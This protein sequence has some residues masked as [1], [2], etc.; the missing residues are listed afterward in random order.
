MST[1]TTAESG[2]A[3]GRRKNAGPLTTA[4]HA[5]SRCYDLTLDTGVLSTLDQGGFEYAQDLSMF[6]TDFRRAHSLCPSAPFIPCLPH[7]SKM[8]G[9]DNFFSPGLMCPTGWQTVAGAMKLGITGEY[10][11]DYGIDVLTLLPDER[12]YVCRPM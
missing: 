4:F 6:V 5:P 12:V 9:R 11:Y 8:Q 1:S 3:T 7:Y 2:Q 10:L